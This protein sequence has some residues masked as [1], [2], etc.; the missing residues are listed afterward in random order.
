[1]PHERRHF[2]RVGFDTTAR[3]LLG[4]VTLGV[5]VVDLS[6]KGA[7]IQ[8]PNGIAVREMAVC[9]LTVPLTGQSGEISMTVKVAHID[10]SLLGLLCT[11]SDIDSVTHLRRVIELQLGDATL[12]E[13]DLAELISA[14]AAPA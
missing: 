12:L 8:L 6:L 1:M 4:E 13:R 14:P 11:H 9:R 7:L 10:G 2:V 3:L 5:K